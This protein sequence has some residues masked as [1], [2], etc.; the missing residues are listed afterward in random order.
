MPVLLTGAA[1]YTGRGL[2]EARG[3]RH[4]VRGADLKDAGSVV[5]DMALGSQRGVEVSTLY[6]RTHVA[7][8][9]IPPCFARMGMK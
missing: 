3:T 5:Q 1:G 6:S 9:M 7:S 2:A 4:W 8:P